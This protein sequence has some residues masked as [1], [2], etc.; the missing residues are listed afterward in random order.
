MGPNTYSITITNQS[1]HSD[2]LMVFQ[3][4]PGSLAPDAMALA[5]FSKFS[6]PGSTDL[7]SWQITWGFSWADTGTLAAGATFAVSQQT[8]ASN[9]N[10]I[11][12]SNNGAYEFVDQTDGPDANLFYIVEDG[13]IPVDASGSVG[14]TMYGN[15]VYAVQATPNTNLTF[16]P[17]PQY[18]LAYGNYTPGLVL[19]L[20]AVNKPLPLTYEAGI[21]SLAVTLNPD[22]SWSTVTTLAEKNASLLAGRK[23]KPQRLAAAR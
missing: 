16:T 21:Y 8:S 20:S 6:N 9:G 12:L 17:H 22:D 15:T 7:F 18:F 4:D 19:D 10:Q 11:T 3:Q 13:S 2:Y 5:W 14:I 23:Q 1:A